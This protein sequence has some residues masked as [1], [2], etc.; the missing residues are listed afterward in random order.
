ME[1]KLYI[2]LLKALYEDKTTP[3]NL[4]FSY[5]TII[6][7]ISIIIERIKSDDVVVYS[8]P[9]VDR[10]LFDGI[11]K[12]GVVDKLVF[13]GSSKKTTSLETY[14]FNVEK[15]HSHIRKIKLKKVLNEK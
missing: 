15:I 8:K 13:I 14:M 1:D 4:R 10:L 2:K 11:I 9:F 5:E 7:D 12:K 3:F 6:D